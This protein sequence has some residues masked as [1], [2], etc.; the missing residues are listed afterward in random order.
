MNQRT[1]LHRTPLILTLLLAAC[2]SPQGKPP[3]ESH[4][5]Q[6][7][8][9]APDAGIPV[10]VS[11]N[12][13]V[14]KPKVGP[15]TETYSVVVNNVRVH[16]LLFA[17]ARDAKVNVDIHPGLQGNVTLNAID[18]TLPQILNRLSKQVDLR[19]ELDGQTL[20]VMPDSPFLHTYRVDYVNMKRDTTGSINV[21]GEIAGGTTG[22]TGIPG[23]GNSS[24][25][26][27]DN[28]A[29]NHFWE[30]LIQNIKDLLHETDKVLPEGSSDT[31]VEQTQANTFGQPQGGN[32]NST[33][34]ST[35]ASGKNTPAIPVSQTGNATTLVKRSTFREAAS[36]IANA[37]TGVI[38][39]RATARQQERVQEFLDQVLTS[40]KRQVLIEATIAEVELSN[41]YQQGVDWSRVASSSSNTNGIFFSQTG[42][43]VAGAGLFTLNSKGYDREN[44]TFTSAIR[45]LENFGTVKII[46]SPKISVINNQSAILKVVDNQVYFTIKANV[47]TSE[48][49]ASTTF[50][51]TEQRV[52]PIG[53][54]MSIT[55]QISGHGEVI[56]NVRPSITR[57]F[58]AAK[59]PNP[60]LTNSVTGTRID[61]LIP[62]VRTREMESVLRL[63]DGSVGVMGGLM[64]EQTSDNDSAVPWFHT[65]PILGALFTQKN[66][67]N[68]KT[69]LVIFLRPTVIRESGINGDFSRLREHLPTKEF[70]A[71]NPGPRYQLLPSQPGPGGDKP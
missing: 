30:T 38:S 19:W 34:S 53:F 28:S 22:S 23:G 12:L 24:S 68:R 44:G 47:I 29:K 45:L 11:Q 25:S 60:S 49:G 21:S 32:T 40:A 50:Y 42:A 39:V 7:A 55:P 59:D 1:A 63:E 64:E 20:A 70:F 48:G 67:E 71:N 17:L 9:P 4:L 10:P 3:S 56:L 18:Q 62:I 15:K 27:I 16:D 69:E 2:A 6:T 8:A 57:I 66:K 61:N 52:V 36:V 13:A 65:I 26:K 46:S 5:T 41:Q 31:L 43:A 58:G 51:S 37:E 14:P 35:S 54:V 33:S